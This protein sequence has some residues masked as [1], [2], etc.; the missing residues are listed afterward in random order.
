V[1][2]RPFRIGVADEVLDDLRRRLDATRW[3]P[4]VEGLGWDD[5]TDVAFARDL[6]QWWRDCYDWRAAEAALN[7]WPQVL[8]DVDGSEVH[9]IHVRGQG[10][11]PIP[12][13]LTHGW[14]STFY[15]MHKVL[16]PLSDPA[17]HGGDA[18]DAFHVVVPSLPGYGWSPPPATRGTD[19]RR[20]AE[21]WVGLMEQLGYARFGSHGGDWGSAVTT[22][23]GAIHPDRMIGLHFAMLSPPVDPAAL[24]AA[25]R[26]WW[27][28]LL[29]YRDEEWGYVHLQRTKPQ[30]ASF[31]LTDSP[32]GLAA[33]ITEKWWRWSDCANEAG[34]RDLWRV[35][36]RDE[37][38]TTVMIYWVTATIGPSM[39]LY[40]ETFGP[41]STIAQPTRIEVP[42]GVAVFNEINR[43][44][45]ALAE[46]W[47]DIRRW[48][49][50]DRGGH[51]PAMENPDALV[52]ELR[53]FFRPLRRG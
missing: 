47:Y 50:I 2:V 11:D 9:C 21:L 7:A 25:Q 42:T 26:A 51:F 29:V 1:G 8:V 6:C 19:A 44:P 5:G 37:I 12:L 15:E 22:A 33:W 39:R 16:G 28:A 17:A 20:I 40:R 38:L 49:A 35:Y 43:P 41:G 53:A 31:G 30:T 32:A 4:T 3:P 23:L 24:D 13:V 36:T 46:P 34:K 10:P 27:D 48:S 45:R 14:P 52:R 18:R